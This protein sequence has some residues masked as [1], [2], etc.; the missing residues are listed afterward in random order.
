MNKR[1]VKVAASL[2]IAT[3]QWVCIRAWIKLYSHII[4]EANMTITS[5]RKMRQ[6][7]ISIRFNILYPLVIFFSEI[8]QRKYLNV[9]HFNAQT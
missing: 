5:V 3:K 7:G 1:R 8:R 6:L 9:Q 2:I 4:V